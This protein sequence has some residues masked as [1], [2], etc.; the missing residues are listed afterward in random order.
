[1]WALKFYG[2]LRPSG[3]GSQGFAFGFNL[4][5]NESFETMGGLSV[6]LFAVL[7]QGLPELV[8]Q[9][10]QVFA[11]SEHE[12]ISCIGVGHHAVCRSV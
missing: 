5:C 9:Q 11:I 4:G 2:K 3:Q 12:I 10:N 1:M 6:M 8:K 7:R